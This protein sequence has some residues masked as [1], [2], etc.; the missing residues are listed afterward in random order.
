M[1]TRFKMCAQNLSYNF[2]CDLCERYGWD[3]TDTKSIEGNK[4]MLYSH[5]RV[6][7][8]YDENTGILWKAVG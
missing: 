1:V 2:A 4:T 6:V 3:V 5:G 8:R 7:G